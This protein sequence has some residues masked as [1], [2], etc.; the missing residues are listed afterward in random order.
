[1]DAC[2][3]SAALKAQGLRERQYL[4]WNK[5]VL[6]L[7]RSDYQWKHEPC[8]YGWKDGA[9]HYFCDSRKESTVIP[10][11]KEIEPSKMKKAELVMLV[12]EIIG[13]NMATDVIDCDKPTRNAEHPTMKP[14]KL[15][16]YL[17]RNSSRKG[18][19]VLDTFAGS[20]TTI[21]A[22]EQQGRKAYCMELDEHYCDVILQRWENFTNKKA[23]KL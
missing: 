8:F 23:V 11:A 20:G 16:A 17:M 7:G 22:A 14:I 21:M 12:K 19:I 4:I 9:S 18:E 15:F 5:N 2:Q 1:M 10:D 6:C 13:S 3:L